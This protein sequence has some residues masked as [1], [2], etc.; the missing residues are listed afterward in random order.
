MV[1]SIIYASLCYFRLARNNLSTM[2]S[3]WTRIIVEV[4]LIK[5]P[6]NRHKGW[7]RL[8]QST[9]LQI[10]IWTSVRSHIFMYIIHLL[11]YSVLDCCDNKTQ[12]EAVKISYWSIVC[13]KSLS[14][15]LQFRFSIQKVVC[16]SYAISCGIDLE[17]AWL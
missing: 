6:V 8:T 12:R 5:E 1:W 7:Q 11:M 9:N 16:T 10:Q 3:V 4:L 17:I 13:A 2:V 15:Y 14:N